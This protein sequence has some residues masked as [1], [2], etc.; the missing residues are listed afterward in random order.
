MWLSEDEDVSGGTVMVMVKGAKGCIGYC[1]RNR[2]GVS[3]YEAAF[4]VG[5]MGR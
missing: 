2:N 3:C 4:A 5:G 1:I